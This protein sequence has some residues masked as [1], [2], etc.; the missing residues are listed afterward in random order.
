MKWRFRRLSA[1]GVGCTTPIL[2][3]IAIM[4]LKGSKWNMN[5]RTRKGSNP[6]RILFL[7]L[8]IAGAIYLERIFVPKAVT[9]WE[10]TATPT[11]NPESFIN[12]ARTFFTE[13]KML[14]SISTYEKAIAANPTDRTIY[15]ELARV[16]VWAGD[17]PGAL[18]N[19]ERSLVG[20]EEYPLGHA[21]R[22]WVLNFQGNY[23]DA[24]IALYR[25]IDLDT[26]NPLPHAYLAETL[27]NKGDYGDLEKAATESKL[28][29]DLDPAMLETI[30]ARAYVL[31][32]TA[33]YEEAL[34]LYQRAIALNRYIPDLYLNL[35]YC[36]KSLMS[37]DYENANR[38][39]DAFLQANSLNPQ[40]SI[41]DLELSR[42][43]LGLGE[44]QRAIQYAENAVKDDPTN[45]ARYGN[46]GKMYYE[47]DMFDQAVQFLRIAIR[48]GTTE[49]G[50]QVEP[51]ILDYPTAQYFYYYG[52]A[53]A[54][55][56]PNQ[57]SEA[58][59]IAQAL[60]N[61]VPSDVYAYENANEILNL[62]SAAP[63]PTA[64]P[65]AE[66]SQP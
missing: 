25:A 63:D 52:L 5:R 56:V 57:C 47:N 45:G 3:Y 65:T 21:V 11:T 10:P 53:L 61:S 29:M 8:L 54:K 27:I 44:Y 66:A 42:L 9:S 48:G 37:V 62:C 6:F 7:L 43:Y 36:Y 41:P 14:Q 23:V 39:A 35:G 51:I 12:E 38:A 26:N 58:V 49:D 22:G 46:L 13:G 33:N 16:Q 24:E 1:C 55:V 34:E 50:Q 19:A 32:N 15:I 20:N 30:R 18:E 64:E 28:A 4:Y 2:W 31:L 40:N 59:P 60:L 17:Y